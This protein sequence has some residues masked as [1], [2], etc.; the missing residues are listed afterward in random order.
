MAHERYLPTEFTPRQL[1]E[2]RM[3][4][5]SARAD[6]P[7]NDDRGQELHNLRARLDSYCDR[8]KFA[9]AG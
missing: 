2:L 6:H 5:G 9:R 4:V 3:L 7:A 8:A 1:E